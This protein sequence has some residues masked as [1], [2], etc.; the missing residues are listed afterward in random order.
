MGESFR[1]FHYY[2][3]KGKQKKSFNWFINKH[4]CCGFS[5]RAYI[6]VEMR[7]NYRNLIILPTQSQAD[8]NFNFNE[9]NMRI[10][11]GISVDFFLIFK[12]VKTRLTSYKLY[13]FSKN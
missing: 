7:Q 6:Y 13:F 3:L 10:C 9:I 12:G 1:I 2:F 8:C 5:D 4:L 11:C